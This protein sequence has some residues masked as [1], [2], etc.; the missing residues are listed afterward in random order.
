MLTILR[1]VCGLGVVASL[2]YYIAATIFGRRFARRASQPAPALPKVAPRVAILKPLSGMTPNLADN[3]VSHL[4]LDYPR[5]EYVFG[6]TTYEDP[7]A[8]VPLGLKARYQFSDI[9][10]TIGEELN[11]ANRKVGKLMRML[12]RAPNAQVV[13]ISDA[14]VEV[15]RTHLRR[16]IGE[17]MADEKTGIVTCAYRSKPLGGIG[18]RL[19]ALFVN[20]DFT[21]MA[22]VSEA[23]EPM[24]H[25]FGAT[26]AIKREA[27][28]AIGGLVRIRDLLAD[29]FFLGRFVAEAGYGIKLSSSIVTTIAEENTLK[30]FW[31]HQLRWARTF[32]TVRPVSLLTVLTHG[33]FWASALMLAFGFQPWTFGVLAGMLTARTAMAAAILNSPLDLPEKLSDLWLL[34]LKDLLITGIWFASLFGRRVEWGGR[35]FRL[36]SGGRMEEILAISPLPVPVAPAP[37]AELLFGSSPA[38]AGIPVEN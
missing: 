20:T 29:D 30:D 24:H 13:V 35:R 3:V 18:S 12:D 38:S 14:D 32:R 33:T 4:E 37:E 8:A 1:V 19:E 10:L 31:T 21:P 11:C 34:P 9:V 17:L 5:K 15:E 23:L 7:A 2:V 16:L 28:D 6:V 25:A 27:L 26:I 22:I 36:L